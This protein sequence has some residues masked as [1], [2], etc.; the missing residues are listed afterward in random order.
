MCEYTFTPLVPIVDTNHMH[1]GFINYYKNN[2]IVHGTL[3][4]D[5]KCG[6]FYFHI[7]YTVKN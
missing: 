4:E 5:Y 2:F 6:N 1:M 7:N 3:V